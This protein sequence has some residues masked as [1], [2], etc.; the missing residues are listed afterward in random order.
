MKPAFTV[1]VSNM[2]PSFLFDDDFP[3]YKPAINL[4]FVGEPS[5]VLPPNFHRKSPEPEGDATHQLP[6]EVRA[7][8]GGKQKKMLPLNIEK[9]LE[10]CPLIVD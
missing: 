6:Q 3:S 5:M 1:D 2:F 9:A 10:T 4:Y 8:H 7:R